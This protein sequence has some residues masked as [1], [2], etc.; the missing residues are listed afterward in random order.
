V[1]LGKFYVPAPFIASKRP[2]ARAGL[3]VEYATVLVQRPG[4]LDLWSDRGLPEGVIVREVV[5]DSPADKAR[6][7]TDRVITHVNGHKVATPAEFYREM[8][9]ARGSVELTVLEDNGKEERVRLD[10]P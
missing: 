8:A 4:V 6:L 9:R 3:R 1:T 7:Q 10:L 5:P 2:P